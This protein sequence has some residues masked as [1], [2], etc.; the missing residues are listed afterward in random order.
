MHVSRASTSLSVAMAVVTSLSA[1][2]GSDEPD[3]HV[4]PALGQRFSLRQL[5]AG[6]VTLNLPAVFLADSVVPVSFSD[7]NGPVSGLFDVF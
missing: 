2:V 4:T 6:N 1:M 7:M 5:S 3:I